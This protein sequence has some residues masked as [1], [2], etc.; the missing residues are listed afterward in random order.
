M[1]DTVYD[2][3]TPPESVHRIQDEDAGL[4][5]VI[6]LHSTRR[7]PAAGG[8]RLWRYPDRAAMAGDAMRLAEGMTY[9]NV[10]AGLPLGGG[11]AVLN[12][13]HGPF[14]RHKLFAA[15]GRAVAKLDGAYVTAEDVGTSV[16]D[17]GVVRGQTRH[18]AGLPPR[19]GR[20]GG[21]PSPHTARGV[22]LA[23]QEAARRQL[24]SELKGMR[25]AVQGLGNVGS[26]LCGMLHQA[27]AR[28]IVAEPRPGV[29]AQ[30]AVRYDAEIMGR[31]TILDA[32]C[33]IFAPCA[34]GGVLD[35][36]AV[37]RLRAR[38]VCGA[39]NNVL[40]TPEDGDRLAERGILYAPDYVVNAG[41]II[42]VAG[43]YLGWDAVEVQARVEA[44]GERL[45]AVLNHAAREGLAPHRAADALARARIALTPA[46]R[47]REAA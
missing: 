12:L 14:D 36:D 21:D 47:V 19:D 26:A 33:T 5:G 7:G 25:V 8:C 40:A 13:P 22:F 38:I 42:S 45:G 35:A 2:S 24:G 1:V 39:A 16:A 11:K 44:S 30:I 28:L 29:A 37:R 41:G 34:L 18:V 20:P 10:M 17:M 4:D 9:K 31:D 23:M 6:V 15:F 43:E 46:A 3:S 32:R 27:G